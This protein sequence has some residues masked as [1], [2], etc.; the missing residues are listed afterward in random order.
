MIYLHH[1]PGRLRVRA[2][3]VKSE[4]RR[5]ALRNWLESLDGVESVDIRPV[6]GSVLV[7][8]CVGVT[9]ADRLLTAMRDRGWLSGPAAVSRRPGAAN[10]G[11]R[12]VHHAIT[13]LVIRQV[14]EMALERG[15]VALC[16][17]LL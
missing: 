4:S 13:K 9:D 16:T 11:H 3:G 14:A 15:I 1:V 6:T 2:A 7:H 5:A 10:P 17:S 12:S 8:Y